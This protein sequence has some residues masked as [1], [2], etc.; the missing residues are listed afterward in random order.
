[1]EIEAIEKPGLHLKP[2]FLI[3]YEHSTLKLRKTTLWEVMKSP[4]EQATHC[5][6]NFK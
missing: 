1:L 4:V 6:N 5:W 2:G 3:V